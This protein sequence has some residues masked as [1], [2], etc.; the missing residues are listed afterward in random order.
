MPNPVVGAVRQIFRMFLVRIGDSSLLL[1]LRRL[2]LGATWLIFLGLQ[3]LGLPFI[4]IP[5]LTL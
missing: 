2:I 4:N 1:P 5:R 3:L